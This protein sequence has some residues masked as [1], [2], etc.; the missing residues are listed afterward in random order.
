MTYSVKFSDKGN[1]PNQH[2]TERGYLRG[3]LLDITNYNS[4][5]KKVDKT[6]YTYRDCGNEQDSI[7]TADIGVVGSDYYCAW[8]GGIYTL[9]Y[10]TLKPATIT[11][12]IY[13]DASPNDS[14]VTTDSYTYL[15]KRNFSTIFNSTYN[16]KTNTTFVTQHL[17]KRGNESYQTNYS[18]NGDDAYSKLAQNFHVLCPASQIVF[19]NNQQVENRTTTYQE[20]I[21]STQKNVPVPSATLK[22]YGNNTD[23]LYLYKSYTNTGLLSHCISHDGLKMSFGYDSSGNYLLWKSIGNEFYTHSKFSSSNIFIPGKLRDSF[24]YQLYDMTDTQFT[25]YSYDY[26][27]GI[28][29]ITKSDASI[30]T[31]KYKGGKLSSIIDNR[32]KEIQSFEYNYKNQ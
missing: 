9:R 11:H 27:F 29:S 28:N 12:T 23:T 13:N 32:N 18:Y 4:N 25:L 19:R 26:L 2:F 8:I 6:S 17:Q 1:F 24:R 15:Y 30:T 5:Y 10:T 22:T 31:Y 3:K 7:V 16:N 20:I 21:T 14:I